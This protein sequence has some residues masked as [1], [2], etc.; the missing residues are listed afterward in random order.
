M[1]RIWEDKGGVSIMAAELSA[2]MIKNM[3]LSRFGPIS[4]PKI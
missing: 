4:G 2:C 3:G 1:C